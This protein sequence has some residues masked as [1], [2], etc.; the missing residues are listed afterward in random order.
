MGYVV[1]LI[2]ILRGGRVD[3]AAIIGLRDSQS[4][5][6]KKRFTPPPAH[7]SLPFHVRQ[8]ITRSASLTNLKTFKD[9]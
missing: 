2:T 3:D 4:I 7:T 5:L 9:D 8:L 1:I 6:Q